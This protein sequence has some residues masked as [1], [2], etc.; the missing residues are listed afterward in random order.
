MNKTQFI[1][2]FSQLFPLAAK[3]W[4]E[5]FLFI[6]DAGMINEELQE[7][8]LI[9]DKIHSIDP[10]ML[11]SLAIAA[12]EFDCDYDDWKIRFFNLDHGDLEEINLIQSYYDILELAHSP[13][14]RQ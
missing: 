5:H 2:R 10:L 12:F 11:K 3:Y 9:R 7:I 4:K 8:I 1:E 14:R 13:H 6:P